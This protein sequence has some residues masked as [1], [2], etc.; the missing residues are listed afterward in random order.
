MKVWLLH[1]E[2]APLY[3]SVWLSRTEAIDC[4]KHT[5]KACSQGAVNAA[6]CRVIVE[7]TPDGTAVILQRQIHQGLPA[8]HNWRG[9]RN[10]YITEKPL[11]GNAITALAEVVE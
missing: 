7:E 4:A 2:K 6:E 8:P 5:A 1:D 3:N 9:V 10:W 11:R